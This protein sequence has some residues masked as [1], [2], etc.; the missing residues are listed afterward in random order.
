VKPQLHETG[1]LKPLK[2]LLVGLPVKVMV[3]G[4]PDDLEDATIISPSDLPRRPVTLDMLCLRYADGRTGQA[5][6]SALR[7]DPQRLARHTAT[8][9]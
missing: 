7:I 2:D 5:S 8:A 3:M 9:C 4:D 6:L 1:P